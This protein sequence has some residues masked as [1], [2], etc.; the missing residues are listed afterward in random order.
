MRALFLSIACLLYLTAAARAEPRIALII[1]NA[2]YSDVA[3]LANA[4]ADAALM[5][6]ALSDVGF[7]VTLVTNASQNEIKRAIAKFGAAL[8]AA[9][10]EAV[11]LFYY[12]GHDVQ[13][14]GANYLLPVDAR[15]TVAAD[16]DL[17]GLEAASVLR[18]MASARNQTNIVILDA[19]RDNPFENVP[20]I[21]DSG[22]A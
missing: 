1:G 4:G 14:F 18:Q 21:N 3:P 7:D 17:V 15:L 22:L 2:T 8:R 20:D 19:C 9:G 10:P 6:S 16:L 12:A 5:S 11:G 13:S